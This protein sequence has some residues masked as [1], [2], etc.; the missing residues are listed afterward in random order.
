MPRPRGPARDQLLEAAQHL[1]LE[2]GYEATALDDVCATAQVTKGGL[3]YHFESKEQLAAAAIERFYGQ[4]VDRGRHAMGAAPTDPAQLLWHYLDAVV[5]LLQDPLLSRG[6]LLGAMALQTPQTHPAVA[7]AA[8]TALE[9]WKAM[10]T[11]LIAAAAR[12]R[13]ASVDTGELADG[14]LAAIEGGLLLDR[15]KPTNPAA[16]AAVTHFGRY[17][18]LLLTQGAT[19]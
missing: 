19:Q 2:R 14:L 10:L 16:V 9:D 8:Q 3:F 5:A 13:A 1:L 7:V 11:E 15:D 12:H 17:L 6:C 4:L 18:R